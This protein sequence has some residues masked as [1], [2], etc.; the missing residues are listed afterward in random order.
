MSGVAVAEKER[1]R[2]EGE[3]EAAVVFHKSPKRECYREARGFRIVTKWK[4]A[5]LEGRGRIWPPFFLG[6]GC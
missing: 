2:G 6:F 3:R 5:R 1:Q 4:I